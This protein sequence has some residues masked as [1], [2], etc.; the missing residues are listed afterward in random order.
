MARS[1]YHWLER[2]GTPDFV[3]GVWI[4]WKKGHEVQGSHSLEFCDGTVGPTGDASFC[5]CAIPAIRNRLVLPSHQKN[6]PTQAVMVVSAAQ[7]FPTL[8]IVLP[9][10]ALTHLDNLQ[11][12]QTK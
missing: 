1:T 4:I 11:G 8:F 6:I 12:T 2:T 10:P 7:I 9:H 3:F 5:H